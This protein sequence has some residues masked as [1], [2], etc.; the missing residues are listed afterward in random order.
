MRLTEEDYDSL[1]R[2][3]MDCAN[4]GVSTICVDLGTDE[5]HVT[6]DV[7]TEGYHDDDYFNGRG[8]YITTSAHCYVI[9][10]DQTVY[11]DEETEVAVDFDIDRFVRLVEELLKT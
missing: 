8:E 4:A 10:Y 11:V 5:F 3:A 6:V 1:V 9:D 7:E 2:Q